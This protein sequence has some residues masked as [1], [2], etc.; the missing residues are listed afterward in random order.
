MNKI[1]FIC[2]ADPRDTLEVYPS[3][4]VEDCAVL[5]A[6]NVFDNGL[7][8]EADIR[9]DAVQAAKLGGELLL[10]AADHGVDASPP[11]KWIEG[12]R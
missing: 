8:L 6:R 3:E 7:I 1:T 9:L 12:G 2:Q 5:F 10:F 4:C 11:P